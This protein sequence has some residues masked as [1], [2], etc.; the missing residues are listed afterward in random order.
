MKIAEKEHNK[1][2]KQINK[3]KPT[4]K[5]TTKKQENL[6]EWFGAELDKG[7]ISKEQQEEF[8]KFFKELN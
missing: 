5:T 3:T 6:P 8:D 2:T 4:E 1:M 7:E